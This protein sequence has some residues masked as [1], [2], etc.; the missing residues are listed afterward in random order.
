[1]KYNLTDS[2]QPR[3][4]AMANPEHLEIL[5]RGV[6]VWNKWRNENPDV[7]PSLRH[8]D[9]Q[10]KELDGVDLKWADLK[11]AD[12]S[13]SNLSGAELVG[14]NL[15]SANIREANLYWTILIE[16]YLM[17]SDLSGANLN[18]ACLWDTN[19]TRSNLAEAIYEMTNAQAPEEPAK[20]EPEPMKAETP[21]ITATKKAKPQDTKATPATDQV[22]EVSKESE[23]EVDNVTIAKQTGLKA[24]PEKMKTETPQKKATKKA[25]PQASTTMTATDQVI[26]VI[27]KSKTGVDNVTISK[28]TGLNQKQVSSALLRLKK[29]G[30]VKSV[31]RGVHTAV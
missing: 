6:E 15:S 25:K 17:G 2:L 20:A 21:P 16:A 11:Q 24:E 10:G 23:T 27:Q 13:K 1:M 5:M 18:K 4:S 7:V 19:L 30:K 29:Y 3:R 31:K 28:Q 26:E 22:L 8:A 12:L 14:A 9:F